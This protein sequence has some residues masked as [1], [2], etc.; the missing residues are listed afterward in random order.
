MEFISSR[1]NSKSN[2][3]LFSLIRSRLEDL[4]ITTCTVIAKS[5]YGLM[6]LLLDYEYGTYNQIWLL[7]NF[8]VAIANFDLKI[9]PS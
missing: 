5:Q 1:V 4:G 7:C 9:R 6:G 8:A 3:L 2:S